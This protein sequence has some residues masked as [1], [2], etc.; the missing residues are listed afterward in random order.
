M[1]APHA[2]KVVTDWRPNSLSF[3]FKAVDRAVAEPNNIDALRDLYGVVAS[4]LEASSDY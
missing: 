4:F 3:Y 1:L 2:D